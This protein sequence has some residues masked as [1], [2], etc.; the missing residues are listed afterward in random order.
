MMRWLDVLRA[1][2]RALLPRRHAEDQLSADLAVPHRGGDRRVH[3]GG[4]VA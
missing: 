3:A 2:V 1:R 4:A